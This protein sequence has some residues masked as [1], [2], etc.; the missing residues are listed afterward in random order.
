[1]RQYA[2]TATGILVPREALLDVRS[3]SSPPASESPPRSPET[4]GPGRT[5]R[6]TRRERA[7]ESRW[8]RS[9]RL[10]A[11]VLAAVAAFFAAY[12]PLRSANPTPPQIIVLPQSRCHDRASPPAS[13]VVFPLSITVAEP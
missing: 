4:R 2:L 10:A 8:I 1:M 13:L 5:A 7:A 3:S 11:L 12:G 6:R 9:D